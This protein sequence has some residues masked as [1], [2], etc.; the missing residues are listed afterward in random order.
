MPLKLNIII[1]STRTPVVPACR[2][3]RWLKNSQSLTARSM[4][5]WSI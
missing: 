3:G 1:G 4:W 5:S 2:I